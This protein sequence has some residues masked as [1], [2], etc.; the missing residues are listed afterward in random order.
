MIKETHKPFV[1]TIESHG[2][3]F[4]GECNWDCSTSDVME[5]MKGLMIAAGFAECWLDRYCEQ[6]LEEAEFNKGEE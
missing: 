5:V 3:K 6:Y 1:L 2:K 4:S